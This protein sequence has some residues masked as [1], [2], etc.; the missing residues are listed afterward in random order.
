M[1]HAPLRLLSHEHQ[2]RPQKLLIISRL[3]VDLQTLWANTVHLQAPRRAQEADQKG[4]GPL[5]MF[6][7]LPSL[8]Q[9]FAILVVFVFFV[10]DFVFVKTIK[11]TGDF[12][13][14]SADQNIIDKY[15]PNGISKIIKLISNKAVKLQ[16]GYIFDYAFIMLIGFS[17]LF[18]IA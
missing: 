4:L 11:K 3:L 15:G 17:L 2:E 7:L 8:A 5:D 9:H 6:P 1:R 10:Y 18:A 16:S 12:L 13:W 14:K